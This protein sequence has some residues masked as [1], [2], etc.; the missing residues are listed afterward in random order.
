[1]TYT[2]QKNLVLGSLCLLGFWSFSSNRRI[3][4]GFLR[5]WLLMKIFKQH[6]NRPAKLTSFLWP[7]MQWILG[8]NTLFPSC[9]AF[10]YQEMLKPYS[11]LLQ[12]SPLQHVI[13]CFPILRFSPT[14]PHPALQWEHHKKLTEVSRTGC[15]DADPPRLAMLQLSHMDMW[16]TWEQYSFCSWCHDSSKWQKHSFHAWSEKNKLLRSTTWQHMILTV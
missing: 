6:H 13:A 5:V 9:L 1:M 8:N 14:F 11:V 15:L 4:R 16:Q 12:H 2:M 7:G 10:S 3:S